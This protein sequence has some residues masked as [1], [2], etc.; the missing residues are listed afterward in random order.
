MTLVKNSTIYLL[1][2]IINAVIPFL[3]LP[4]LT[5]YLT[6]SEYGQVA[7]FQMLVSGLAA[8]VG[9][10]AVGA[11]NRKFY[12][13]D[14]SP[15]LLREFNGICFQIL[16][17]STGVLF[18]IGFLFTDILVYFLSIPSYWIYAALM[19]SASSFVV[20]LRLGQ[21]Q[22][23]G[24][25][26]RYGVLQISNSLLNMLL[27][28]LFVVSLKYGSQGRVDGQVIAIVLCAIAA[29]VSLYKD[30]LI[31]LLVLRPE[32]IKFAL[33][34][35]VPLIPHIFGFFLLSSVDRFVINQK[36]GLS[37]AGI[38]M[39][40]VQ[41]SL[42]FNI[43]FDAINKA[44]VPWLF[45]ILK[46]DQW[47]EKV[48]VVRATYIYFIL[49]IVVSPLPF[50][51]G[52]WLLVLIAGEEY[53]DAGKVIGWLCLGQIFGGMYLMVTNYI[54]YAKKTMQLSLVT[55]SSGLLNV[56]LLFLLIESF[57]LQGAAMAF[58]LS[59]LIQFLGT[60]FLAAQVVTMPWFR[61]I[62]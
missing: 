11:A 42:A 57:G 21:W 15:T 45:E 5:R 60:W 41:I 22:I 3:L 14:C 56:G 13:S 6:P 23:R 38:Y 12:D 30:K 7:M 59:K 39:V 52:P 19:F 20:S 1:S 43:V 48:K 34:F 40:A 62:A 50:I 54:F 29:T 31:K 16:I 35:G 46:R 37:D 53:R 18:L 24:E 51:F 28:L 55:I 27:S 17:V 33:N 49:I 26:F 10:N 9:L 8:F 61:A 47:Y 58:V 2:N 4:V 44:F 36:L 32:A 25:A